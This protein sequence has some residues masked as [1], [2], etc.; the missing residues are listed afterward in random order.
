M[1]ELLYLPST[2]GSGG[3]A[4]DKTTFF[5][6]SCEIYHESWTTNLFTAYRSQ[7]S[8]TRDSITMSTT[9]PNICTAEGIASLPSQS[10]EKN[11]SEIFF[12]MWK[13]QFEFSL[14]WI[15]QCRFSTTQKEWFE[16]FHKPGSKI[17]YFL[18]CAKWIKSWFVFK[19]ACNWILYSVGLACPDMTKIGTSVRRSSGRRSGVAFRA[20]DCWQ[21]RSGH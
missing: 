20:V 4:L 17:I 14:L 18:Q 5:S 7:P 1:L 21:W 2:I 19:L 8:I 10:P 16:I 13:L 3:Q 6:K 12:T 11:I 9:K 15:L